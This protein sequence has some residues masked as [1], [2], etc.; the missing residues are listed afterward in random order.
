MRKRGIALACLPALAASL[1]LA[2]PA[3]SEPTPAIT[4]RTDDPAIWGQQFPIQYD[5]Y[6]KTFEMRPTKYGGSKPESRNA[7]ESD[8]RRVVAQS[9][10]NED[11]GL[12]A[13]WQGYAFA[14]DF[15]EERGHMYMLEDQQYTLRQK[16]VQQPGACLNCHASMYGAY[17]KAGDGD[18]MQGFRKINSMPYQ[19]AAKQVKHPVACVDC[20]EAGSMQLRVTRPAFIEGIRAYKASLG[21]ADYDVNK[22]AT[23]EEKRA[24]V[25]G[26]C[27]VEYYFK[28]PDKQLT[29]PWSKGL[30]VDDIQRYYDEIGFRD[31]TH[32]D[33]GAA[34]LKAQHPEFEMWSQGTH[35]RAG[36]TCADC[37]M[38]PVEHQGSAVTDHWVRSPLLNVKAACVS[39]H[40]KHDAKV[41]EADLKARVE[42]IQDRHW[43]LRQQAMAALMG[44]I[45]DLK[46]AKEAGRPDDDLATARYLQRRAQFYLDFVEAENSTGFHAPQEAARVLGQ[47]IDY[48]RQGQIALRDRDFKPTVAIVNLPP[49]PP[50]PAPAPAP[51]PPAVAVK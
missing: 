6:L 7:T 46:A 42:Q 3:A 25:C 37:H 45:G 24:Y 38:P 39:C 30:R 49:P 35:A 8:P 33:T 43:A 26:Q 48:S 17:L 15:R 28:G 18:I 20:H 36:V 16:V 5:L 1:M 32:K 27:H 22:H 47:S 19:E 31:W 21:V 2:L 10:V 29:Y 40:S 44:L 12:K 23:A 14:A 50:A 9:K 41:T 11:P 13:M 51:K 34:A 4:D